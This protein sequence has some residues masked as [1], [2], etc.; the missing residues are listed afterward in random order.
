MNFL[1]SIELDF[2]CMK[3]KLIKNKKYFQQKFSRKVL[4]PQ[5]IAKEKYRG[6]FAIQR[7]GYSRFY[8]A[9]QHFTFT[10]LLHVKSLW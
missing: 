2:I 10:S 8:V 1:K 5:A 4:V 9:G 7:S 3:M 6:V